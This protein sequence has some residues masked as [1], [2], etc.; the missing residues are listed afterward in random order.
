[1][2]KKEGNSTVLL[3]ALLGLIAGF[4]AWNYKRNLEL[5]DV[6]PRPYRGYALADLETLK[7]AYQVEADKHLTRYQA[8]ST[9]TV[10]VRGG[11]LIAQQ[12]DEFERVQ[13]IG[14]GKRAIA[15]D[16]AKNQVQ[17]DEINAELSLRE[18]LGAGW[19]LHLRRLTKYP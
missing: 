11:G 19:E 7:S 5:E 2:A 10:K 6:Q 15:S 14:N 12:V 8:A 1:V 9:Q 4:G 16:F 17:L 3:L 13:R 18:S